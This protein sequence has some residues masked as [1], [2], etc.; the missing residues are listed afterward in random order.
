MLCSL[1]LVK[2]LNNLR[3]NK[4]LK[5]EYFIQQTINNLDYYKSWLFFFNLFIHFNVWVTKVNVC[6]RLSYLFLNVLNRQFSWPLSRQQLKGGLQSSKSLSWSWKNCTTLCHKHTSVLGDPVENKFKKT[7]LFFKISLSRQ[8][9][10]LD[11]QTN[12]LMAYEWTL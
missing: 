7:A 5:N 3:L 11:R 4:Y 1:I 2:C 10:L 9:T 6:M 8:S 12:N